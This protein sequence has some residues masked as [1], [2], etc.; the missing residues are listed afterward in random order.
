[1]TCKECNQRNPIGNKFCR[2]CGAKIVIPEGSLAAEEAVR[3]ESERRAER[4]AV[5]LS[6]AHLLAE[7]GKF[8]AA[9]PVA[10]EAVATLP[11][12]ASA[13]T[14]LVTL[15]EHTDQREK[16]VAAQERVVELLPNVAG[17]VTRLERLKR[18]ERT[19][20]PPNAI[21]S[22]NWVPTLRGATPSTVPLPLP[23]WFPI[24]AGIV[25]GGFALFL[26]FLAMTPGKPKA[27][28][29]TD[30]P[31]PVA[32]ISPAP[33]TSPLPI[34]PGAMPPPNLD[35]N[36]GGDPFV[37]LDATRRGL[38]QQNAPATGTPAPTNITAGPTLPLPKPLPGARNTPAKPG[39]V[40]IPA[41]IIKITKGSGNEEAQLPPIDAAPPASDAGNSG[42]GNGERV[43]AVPP[44]SEGRPAKPSG[45][46]MKITVNPRSATSPI[47]VA[48]PQ[49]ANSPDMESD[50]MQRARVLQGLGRYKDAVDSYQEAIAAGAPVGDAQ[51]GI[52]LCYQRAN[53]IPSAKVAYIQAIAAYKAQIAAGR[54]PSAAQRGLNT[55]EAALG[56][57][58]GG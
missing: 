55:C 50:P 20:A 9:I 42:F 51:Q 18:G 23:Q 53:D 5:L 40:V 39:P 1:M 38:Q 46:Y 17:E 26:G 44:T 33:Q 52:G 57:L 36:R 14:L 31:A 34:N 56:V 24:A 30:Q 7:Q 28:S 54:N 3:A 13:L 37:S 41:D 11:F 12:S 43:A 6:D 48:P 22:A 8:V 35:P 19:S 47:P 4:G 45:G 29:L 25:G 27:N 58:N 49:T 16:A 2:E 21:V 10:E 15:Y 32:V